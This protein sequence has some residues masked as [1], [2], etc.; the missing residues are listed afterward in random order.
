MAHLKKTNNAIFTTNQ[1]EKMSKCPSSKWQQDLN[2]KPF[3]H[4]LSPV[5]L[6]QGTSPKILIFTMNA[7]GRA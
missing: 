4:E 1:C 5:K 6:D 2:P 7:N 3:K